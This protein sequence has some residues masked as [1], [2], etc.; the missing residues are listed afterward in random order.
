MFSLFYF[1]HQL[2]QCWLCLRLQLVP[3]PMRG[4]DHGT[5][6]LRK[7]S[8]NPI[9][10]ISQVCWACASH[11][12]TELDEKFASRSASTPPN[13]PRFYSLWLSKHLREPLYKIR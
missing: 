2:F 6:F 10:G 9:I 7:R 12:M 3:F 1:L 5:P 8:N 13:A 11:V 4:F